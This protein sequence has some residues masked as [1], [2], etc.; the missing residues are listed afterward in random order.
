MTVPEPDLR[1]DPV[2]AARLIVAHDETHAFCAVVP[3]ILQTS[4]FTFESYDEMV[5]TL[6]PSLAVSVANLP[7]LQ[8]VYGQVAKAETD[9]LIAAIDALRADLRGALGRE[10]AG[11][12]AA[13][14]AAALAEGFDGL[15]TALQ[16]QADATAEV[17]R[18][19]RNLG[20]FIRKKVA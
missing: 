18:E 1:P 8:T 3:P 19:N 20:A 2:E 14:A 10:Q 5:A 13:L 9:R 11:D 4:L 17:A 15:S 7:M 16:S 12:A 6:K